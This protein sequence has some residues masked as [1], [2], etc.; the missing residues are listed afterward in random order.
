MMMRIFPELAATSDVRPVNNGF[1][2]RQFLQR[3]TRPQLVFDLIFGVVGPVL[4]FV[5]DPVVFQGG[6]LGRPF[7]P[8]YQT[9]VY[10]FSGI[11]MVLLCL[12][13]VM[14]VGSELSNAMLGGALMVGGVFCSA[15][16][17]LL[18]PFS[19]MGLMLGIG[20]LGFTPFM[21]ALVYLRNG[22]RALRTHA[23]QPS[24]FTRAT[25]SACGLLLVA[26]IPIALSMQI[27]SAVVKSVDYIIRADP[28]QAPYAA[29]QLAVPRYFANG[30]LE[31]I[32][33]AYASETDAKRKEL[34]GS[35]YREITGE[36][37]ETRLR[38][39]D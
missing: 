15:I 4:C 29:Q 7:F 16:G 1:W 21:T 39:L 24:T 26:G 37:I 3:S 33:Q 9:F 8:E 6:L 18:F 28:V 12:W 5:F 35:Y 22:W 25:G 14:G 34:L 10:L 20:L 36:D 19:V 23:S 17:I 27:R 13:L 30:D 31:R 32:V 38:L 11:E 2:K